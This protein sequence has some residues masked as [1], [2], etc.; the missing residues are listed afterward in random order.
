MS[1]HLSDSI[2]ISIQLV[3]RFTNTSGIVHQQPSIQH[4]FNLT[5]SHNRSA[6]TS[7]GDNGERS[8]AGCVFDS[9]EGVDGVVVACHWF[10][11]CVVPGRSVVEFSGLGLETHRI[12]VE[13]A[14]VVEVSFEV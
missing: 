9:D 1:E 12:C 13:G 2:S 4:N 3:Q 11:D 10:E 14:V 7:I 8:S 6:L 5:L